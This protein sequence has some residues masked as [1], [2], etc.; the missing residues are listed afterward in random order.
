M[1]RVFALA[2]IALLALSIAPAAA[3]AHGPINPVASSYLAKVSSSPAGVQAKVV[4][5]DLRMWLQVPYNQTLVVL[6]YRGAPYLRFT[7]AGVEVNHKSAMYYLNQTPVAETPPA[8]LGRHTPP[9]WQPVTSGHDY[10]WHDG[11]LH[12]LASV[13]LVPGVAY[14]GTWRI[15]IVV[16]GRVSAISGGLWHAADPSVVWFWPIVV[17]LFCLLA[18][19]RIK[20]PA[21]DR[22]TA[23][24]LAFPALAATVT[25]A[26]G[27]DLHG[28]P[29]LSA[30]QLIELA[31]VL[32]FVAW[33]L[34][35]I[36]ARRASYF[37][38]LAIAIIALWEG[39]VLVPTLL[40]GFVLVALP[41]FVARSA[42][43][44]ALAGGAGLLF[45]VF[46]LYDDETKANQRSADQQ[47]GGGDSELELV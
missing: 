36:L 7:R 6:D 46:R 33:A 2:G 20:S 41:A 25:A 44:L 39:A 27:R 23:R 21:L 19:W 5:G 11:R 22:W 17:L 38:Y 28:R 16:N 43:V 24:T 30:F 4:D 29:G 42:S 34:S 12:A 40:H 32:A 14:V 1:A 3:M 26:L 10:S 35:R 15:P 31:L 13:A 18:A 8:S 9:R 37:T 45:L 47:Q